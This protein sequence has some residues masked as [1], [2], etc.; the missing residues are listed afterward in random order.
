MVLSNKRITVL[1]L[2]LEEL[3]LNMIEKCDL[4]VL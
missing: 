3:L 2:D 4:F 1:V